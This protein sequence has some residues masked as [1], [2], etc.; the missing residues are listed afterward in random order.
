MVFEN[1]LSM[2]GGNTIMNQH[3]NRT[4]G[5]FKLK[6]FFVFELFAFISR[7]THTQCCDNFWQV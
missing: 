3:L 4:S 6:I 7:C 2:K 5:K 1:Q